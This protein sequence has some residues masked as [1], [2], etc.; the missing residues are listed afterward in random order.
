M[1]NALIAMTKSKRANSIASGCARVV[2]IDGSFTEFK[3]PI[4]VAELMMDYPQHLVCHSSAVI[5]TQQQQQSSKSRSPRLQKKAALPADVQLELGRLYYLL[6][7]SQFQGPLVAG[8]AHASSGAA[9]A[10]EKLN[11]SST[12]ADA[13]KKLSKEDA[14]STATLGEI[15]INRLRLQGLMTTGLRITRDDTCVATQ[16]AHSTL[17]D[18]ELL[19]ELMQD[20]EQLPIVSFS[21]PDLRSMYM[22]SNAARTSTAQQAASASALSTNSSSSWK[23]RLE[24]IQEVG[25]LSRR[26]FY[27]FVRG[28]RRLSSRNQV[29]DH[30][31]S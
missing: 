16:S 5:N 26:R 7:A 9:A 15:L 8:L 28:R 13:K 23:P 18:E 30:L 31:N 20:S 21:T 14:S 27:N 25:A 29:H 17:E 24:T 6:P 10:H 19:R 12:G 11:R 4:T 22:M 1:G 3:E 2:M